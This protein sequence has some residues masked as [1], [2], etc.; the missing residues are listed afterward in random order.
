MRA[1]ILT[2]EFFASRERA[3]L[4]R[5]EVGLADEGVR[6][7]HAVPEGIEL[8]A[9]GGVFTRQVRYAPRTLALTRRL[10]MRRLAHELEWLDES[11]EAGSID[12]VHVFGGAA[13]RLGVE[14]GEEIG[15][16]VALE[17]WRS[18][19]IERAKEFASRDEHPPLLLAPDPVIERSILGTKGGPALPVRLTPWGVLTPLEIR[20]V[21]QT[22]R[23]ATAMMVGS[24]RDP[25]AFLAAF[26]G[27]ASILKD[28]PNLLIFCDALAAHRAGVWSMARK[29]GV[30]DRVSLIDELEARRD[31]LLHGDML[32]QPEV[33]GEQR[34]IVIEA[35]AAGMV[36]VAGVDPMVS[37]LQ[38]GLTCRAVM[39]RDRR[40]WEAVL[41]D[42]LANPDRSR[43][44]ARSAHDFVAQKRK[45]SDHIRSVLQAYSWLTSGDPLPF[46]TT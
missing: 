5:L 32:I 3:F 40:E 25:R 45:A 15:A 21:L 30:L 36:V 13:W 4:Q 44:L 33:Q 23:A 12:V 43:G 31:L 41:R 27:L 14:L 29:L 7:L 9:E 38:D 37:I 39:K 19:L 1:L 2:D 8:G 20:P 11:E 35:M 24:G 34:S 42:V 26:E 22:G 17:V 6:V 10:A 16:G 28:S 18:G 46:K